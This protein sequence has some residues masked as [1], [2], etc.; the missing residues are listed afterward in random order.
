MKLLFLIFI[1]LQNQFAQINIQQNQI[2]SAIDSLQIKTIVETVRVVL[3]EN[4]AKNKSTVE[5]KNFFDEM[6]QDSFSIGW[7]ILLAIAIIFIMGYLNYRLNK[8]YNRYNLSTRIRNADFIKVVLHILIWTAT[9]FVIVFTLLKTSTLLILLFLIFIFIVLIISVSDLAK[10][11]ISGI[12]ILIDKPFEYGDWIKIGQYSG[13]VHSK[14]LRNT[15]IITEDDSLVK[16][17]NSNFITN[18]FENLNVISKNKQVSFIVEVP[19]HSE[20]SKIKNSL[21]EIVSLSIYNSINKPVEVIYK[22]INE[23]GKMEFQIKA[24][25]FDAKYESEFKSDVQENIAE[26]FGIS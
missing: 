11:I 9:I 16:I 13:K 18:A 15:E 8:F 22:G 25:V 14:N 2:N 20:I 10:N 3:Q 12:L 24:Y 7:K 19:P 4:P 26:I 1:L 21:N 6:T 17:P 23:R 5:I